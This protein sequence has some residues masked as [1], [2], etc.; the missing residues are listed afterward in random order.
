MVQSFKA[1]LAA[2]KSV[3]NRI[4][5]DHAFIMITINRVSLLI[6]I[7][8]DRHLF[9]FFQIMLNNDSCITYIHKFEFFCP[10]YWCNKTLR[11]LRREVYDRCPFMLE[12]VRKYDLIF[13]ETFIICTKWTVTIYYH[14]HEF[15]GSSF[16]F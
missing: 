7:F 15:S 10:W 13:D 1:S 5:V 8:I 12:C 2:F 3:F 14:L 4:S 9:R 6:R 16:I 11:C